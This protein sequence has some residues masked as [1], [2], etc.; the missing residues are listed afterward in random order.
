M[1]RAS[2]LFFAAL[3]PQDTDEARRAIA[4]IKAH[5]GTVTIDEQ[6]PGKPVV[7]VNL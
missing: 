5:E 2:L 6:A 3:F 7:G 4:I 1:I